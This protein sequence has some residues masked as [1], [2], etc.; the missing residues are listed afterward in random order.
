MGNMKRDRAN[1]KPS[2]RPSAVMPRFP[3]ADIGEGN[4]V[5][6]GE[7]ED[8]NEGESK[9]RREGAGAGG[10]ST[11]TKEEGNWMPKKE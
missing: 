6:G 11:R 2:K 4:P 1:R 3:E 7:E 10:E 8:S 9:F 5:G